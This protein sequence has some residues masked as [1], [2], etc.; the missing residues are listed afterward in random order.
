[1]MLTGHPT[2]AVGIVD[3]LVV[4]ERPLDVAV[5]VDHG[6]IFHV[7]I[8]VFAGTASPGANDVAAGQ[9]LG[10]EAIEVLEVTNDPAVHV[11]HNDSVAI[12]IVDGVAAISLIGVIDRGTSGINIWTSHVVPFSQLGALPR[13]F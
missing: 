6:Q 4:V 5:H 2:L 8:A 9:N 12:C 13:R 7:L 10:R 3:Q 11:D 1:M